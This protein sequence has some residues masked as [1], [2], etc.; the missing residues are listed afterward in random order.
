MHVTP[1]QSAL[2]GTTSGMSDQEHNT[3]IHTCN[4]ITPHC[5][6]SN[7]HKIKHRTLNFCISSSR[8]VCILGA[9]D[10]IVACS[11]NTSCWL[12]YSVV[13]Y[14]PFIF[15]GSYLCCVSIEVQIKCCLID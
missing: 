4:S 3:Y 1:R 15:L 5:E 8:S 6:V 7:T 9:V 2:F 14:R 12:L 13:C 11:C 10:L